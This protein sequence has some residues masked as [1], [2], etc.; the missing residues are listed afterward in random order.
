MRRASAEG[1]CL[2]GAIRYRVTGDPVAATLCHCGSCRRASGGTNVAWAVFE[3]DK[4]E[5]LAEEATAYSSSPGIDWIFCGK[6]G[7]LV[8][9][10]RSSRPDHMD[11]TTG[12][13]DDADFFP[14]GVEIW[15]EQ[16]IGWETLHPDLPKRQQSSL[17]APE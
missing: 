8:G 5:W 4:F 14:P 17:N 12:T 2:C 6:C 1:G 16:K 10:R 13:L 7:S 11:I 9:Y 15:L 3:K